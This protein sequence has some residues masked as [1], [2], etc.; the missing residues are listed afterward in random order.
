M[1]TFV[2]KM[3]I[4]NYYHAKLNFFSLNAY[5]RY[6]LILRRERL[7]E[8]QHTK[9]NCTN[10]IVFTSQREIFTL[11][12]AATKYLERSHREIFFQ[13]KQ[14]PLGTEMNEL[15]SWIAY[16]ERG[17][18]DRNNAFPVDLVPKK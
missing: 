9:V 8:K 2:N 13:S 14:V 5:N 4:S 7:N 11:D 1:V 15:H 3:Y 6:F 17:Y 10:S 12:L 18:L 16:L